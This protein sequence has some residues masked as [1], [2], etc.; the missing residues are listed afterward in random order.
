MFKRL[1]ICFLLSLIPYG[2]FAK[3]PLRVAVLPW[4]SYSKED[5]SLLR[6]E[7]VTVLSSRLIILGNLSIIEKDSLKDVLPKG[8]TCEFN[9]ELAREI[10][11]RVG[12]D[13]VIWGSLTKIAKN[14][15][16]DVWVLEAGKDLPA[17][18]FFM[19]AERTEDLFAKM[20]KFAK[21]VV[22]KVAGGEVIVKI[23]IRGN[24]MTETGAIKLKIR[25][26]EGDLCSQEIIREDIKN[27][28]QMGYFKDIK[29]EINDLPQGK[30]LVF[31]VQEKP[32]IKEI[33]I[34]GNE[35][36]ETSKIEEAMDIK[37]HSPFDL[38]SVKEYIKKIESFYQEK[39]FYLAKVD[40][41]IKDLEKDELKIIFKIEE[42]E[43]VFIRKISFDITKPAL[44]KKRR[45]FS[46]FGLPGFYR[47]IKSSVGG[48]LPPDA[49]FDERD[50][51]R[52]IETKSRGIFSWIT[53]SGIY[54]QDVLE[55]DL[56][57]ISAFYY[58]H[59]YLEH[60]VGKP[61]IELK[62]KG[63]YIT[64]RID[65]GVQFVVGK[66][67]FAGDLISPKN[68][69]LK[70]LQ[71]V[72]GNVFN[73][74]FLGRDIS[75][76]TDIYADQ[77]YAFVDITPRT[78]MEH[79]NQLVDIVFD[80]QK[81]EKVYIESIAIGGN[82]K[83]RDKVIRRE[84]TIDEGD[85][86][87]ASKLKK[88]K[89]KVKGLG[90]FKE[91]NLKTQKGSSDDKIRLNL[92]VEEAPTASFS[93]GA[94]FSSVDS[95]VGMV[96]LSENNLLGKGIKSNISAQLGRESSRF[97]L[98]VT[99]PW[100]FDTPISGNFNLFDWEREYDD[101]D[102]ETRGGEFGLGFPLGEDSRLH[103]NYR[104]EKG[105]ISSVVWD[106]SWEV[107]EEA[108][109]GAT[110]TS[111]IKA[112]IIY[113]SLNSFYTPTQGN[114]SKFS[115]E[116][117][118]LGGDNRF[119]KLV[120]SSSWYFPVWEES[121]IMVQGKAG[122]APTFGG[123]KLPV[124]ERFFLGGLNSIRGFDDRDVGPKIIKLDGDGKIID[125]DIIG[126]NKKLLFNVEYLFPLIKDA[127]MR[128]VFFFDAGTSF[129]KIRDVTVLN[130]GQY[131]QTYG[132]EGHE[133][134][135]HSLDMKLS[136]GFGVRWHSPMG[137]LRIEWGYNLNPDDGEDQSNFAFSMGTMF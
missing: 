39:G 74:S 124:F 103:L 81:K 96:Q 94:G 10:A 46:W 83:T 44:S 56:R 6:K 12:A 84:L 99:Q 102:Q 27:I 22:A 32:S 21:E 107:I 33:I 19:Q 98:G 105:E 55:N 117:A 73:R 24:K 91:V 40:Y 65:E 113:N 28:Y 14:F 118:G 41:Q 69:L 58:N 20:D 126:G 79:E 125:T 38:N 129:G 53:S 54:Q 77:G 31:I 119:I 88:S 86:F 8:E 29:V 70:N 133:E 18:S 16:L 35:K 137:P 23:D 36:I 114:R 121:A 51:K 76:L 101:F 134:Y 34:L 47:K 120:A 13:L 62:K 127:G 26:K 110:S 97:I 123:K 71:T 43:K 1:I 48:E 4:Q 45:R 95:L 108:A 30:E 116:F 60:Q 109:A 131:F 90:Y 42:N 5:I 2:S 111:S 63:I 9:Q 25:S 104:F 85:I 3:E 78:R 64:I 67:D 75:G 87:S 135:D 68:D 11:L 106:A 7:I 93:F 50:M 112:S 128:G 132:V 130:Q 122:Y 82:T 89:E 136:I 72:P 59:G 52:L 37:P 57:K 92:E 80:I 66:V 115:L 49:Y 15:S 61:K 100:L 17:S